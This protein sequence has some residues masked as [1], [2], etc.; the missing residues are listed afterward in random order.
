[1]RFDDASLAGSS[2]PRLQAFGDDDLRLSL[3][4]RLR[5]ASGSTSVPAAAV[6]RKRVWRDVLIVVF[7]V[8]LG[9]VAVPFA[10]VANPDHPEAQAIADR[11]DSAWRSIVRDGVA[12]QEAASAAGLAVFTFDVD[13]RP[14]IVLTQSE[15]TAAG[16]CYAI[17]FGPGILTAAGTLAAPSDGCTPQSPGRFDQGNSWAEVLPSERIT[18]WWFLPLMA[19]ACAG[20]LYAATDL[21]IAAMIRSR[22][23]VRR[24]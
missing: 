17:R 19:L 5:R 24:G 14:R 13:E 15:P 9:F 6:L 3:E 4:H 7:A 11:L 1:M 8:A 18:T 22:D 16:V 23:R 12:P 21:A 2:P 10:D 20:V